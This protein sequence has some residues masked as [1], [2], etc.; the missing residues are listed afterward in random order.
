MEKSGSE[1]PSKDMASEKDSKVR[2]VR[3]LR[4]RKLLTTFLTQT[5][6]A[7]SI[8][9]ATEE[10]YQAVLRG[11]DKEQGTH[12][13]YVTGVQL[14][15]VTREHRRWLADA[16]RELRRARARQR[17][18]ER[19]ARANAWFAFNKFKF[20]N[21]KQLS[22]VDARG[23]SISKPSRRRSSPYMETL[24][25]WGVLRLSLSPDQVK[26]DLEAMRRG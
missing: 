17:T 21:R 24:E 18:A 13:S 11:L 14:L 1:T 15:K 3:L 8:R 20:G 4:Y 22:R 6:F 7:G 26:S 16:T 25:S 10:Q 12:P 2:G 9:D 5:S 23:S 19:V